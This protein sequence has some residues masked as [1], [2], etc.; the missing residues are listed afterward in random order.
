M[1]WTGPVIA[2]GFGSY[3]RKHNGFTVKGLDNVPA[4]GPYIIAPNHQSYMDGLLVPAVLSTKA[5]SN[6]YFY[7]KSQHVRESWKQFLAG[8]HNIIIMDMSSLK[9]S[10]QQLGEVLKTG[11]NLCIFPEGTRTKTGKVGKFKK[12]FAILSKE[13]D[14][15]VVPV[16]IKGAFEAMPKGSKKLGKHPIVVEFLSPMKANDE[17]NYEAFADDVRKAIISKI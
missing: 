15:P 3:I 12:T 9:D 6:L 2:H 11:H 1:W 4:N 17:Q 10:I 16:V 8:K 7:A 14:I 13:L 5:I